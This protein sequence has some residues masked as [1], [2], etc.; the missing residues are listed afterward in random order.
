MAGVLSDREILDELKKD[1]IVISPFNDKL[2]GN[3]SVDV[4]LGDNYYRHSGGPAMGS[5]SYHPSTDIHLMN[6]FLASQVCSYWG[7]PHLA[8]VVETPE[9]SLIHHLPIG[10]SYILIN[11]HE[12]LLVHTR[13]FIGAKKRITTMLKPRSSLGRVGI[14]VTTGG[15]GDIGFTNR[16][17]L[18]ITNNTTVKMVLPVGERIA[19]IVF[20]WTGE[21]V[22]EYIEKGQYQK[23]TNVEE[24]IRTWGPGMML[25]AVKN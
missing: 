23:T 25:P 12:T 18:A 15:W 6:P 7:N 5:E 11:P 3:C 16:W 2:V 14:S 21:T 9:S 13:E 4:T 20:M 1:N 19:Q 24:M 10:S 17:T 8:Q 22:K